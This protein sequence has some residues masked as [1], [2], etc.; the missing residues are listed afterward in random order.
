QQLILSIKPKKIIIDSFP[1]GIR[2]ELNRL[3]ALENISTTLIARSLR[4]QTYKKYCY[5]SSIKFDQ[6]LRIEPLETDYLH[7]LSEIS[8]TIQD[9]SLS[10]YCPPSVNAMHLKGLGITDDMPLWIVSHSG[11]QAEVIELLDY[12]NDMMEVE[13]VNPQ[14]LLISPFKPEHG[15]KYYHKAVFPAC[16][17]FDHA[18]RIITGCGFNSMQETRKY[19]K[20]HFFI[21]FYRR[22]DDQFARAARHRADCGY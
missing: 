17:Y 22:Y 15:I 1:C 10:D 12:A 2:G 8:T 13:K 6:V 4:W 21:P 20:R 19:R 9:L 7:Y 16:P 11:P 14:V 5:L 18:E 3:P